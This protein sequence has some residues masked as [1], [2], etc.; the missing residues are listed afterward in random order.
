MSSLELS[1]EFEICK[2]PLGIKIK[3][4]RAIKSSLNHPLTGTIHVDEF[5]IG[6]LR[7]I[8]KVEIRD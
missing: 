8:K 5:M 3:V 2:N 7:E 1:S 6:S 4:Q